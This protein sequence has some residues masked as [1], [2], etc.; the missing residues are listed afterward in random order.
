MFIHKALTIVFTKPKNKNLHK[1]YQKYLLLNV[2][3]KT[4]LILYFKSTIV[5]QNLMY[6][7]FMK[8]DTFNTVKQEHVF[9]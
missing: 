1:E 4:K 6:A 7:K 5:N 9:K 8:L 3:T 2:N